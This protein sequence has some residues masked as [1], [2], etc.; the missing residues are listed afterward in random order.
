MAKKQKFQA[1]AFEDPTVC[2]EPKASTN[3][4]KTTNSVLDEEYRWCGDSIPLLLK[5]ILRELVMARLAREAS[6]GK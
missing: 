5:A 4:V 1:S 2:E 6:N 3:G